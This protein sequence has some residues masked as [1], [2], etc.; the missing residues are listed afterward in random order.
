[1][2][3]I[4][5]NTVDVV[6]ESSNE[7]HTFEAVRT[8]INELAALVGYVINTLNGNYVV[9]T[10]DHGFLFTETAPDETDKSELAEKPDGTVTAK[11]RY[12]LG[13]HLPDSDA[14]WHGN[15]RGHGR[16]RG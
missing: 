8:A 14:A 3:Y 16:C 11:N 10:A 1:M 2:V 15:H 7:G 6:G 5:H 9:I 12:L 4:Y 13:H